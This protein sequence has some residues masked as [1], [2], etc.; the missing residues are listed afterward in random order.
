MTKIPAF[1]GRAALVTGGAKRIGAAITSALAQAGY[2]LAIHARA[3]TPAASALASAILA[4]GGRATVV[5]ADLADH[6][7]L[8]DLIAAA[9]AALGP[10]TLLVNCASMFERDAIGALDRSLWERQFAVNLAAPMFLAEAFA[11]QIPNGSDCAVINVTDQRVLNP[12][13]HFVSYTLSKCALHIATRT[14]ALALA[15]KIRVNAVAPGP[16]L[17]SPRQ[18]EEAFARQAASVPLGHGPNPEEIAEAVLFL[19][20]ARSVTGQTLV[21]DGGQHLG[22]R[23]L[24]AGEVDE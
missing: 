14:L 7:Q 21:V 9:H 16:T 13:P 4:K 17:P 3:S 10:L 1:P 15:P 20:G 5:E 24:H 6:A 12:T 18:N 8:P 19:A 11:A 22:W 2:G 23:T